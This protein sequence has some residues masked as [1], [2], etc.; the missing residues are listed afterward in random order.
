[1]LIIAGVILFYRIQFVLTYP[2]RT[3]N[4]VIVPLFK[5]KDQR[6][7]ELQYGFPADVF[8]RLFPACSIIAEVVYGYSTYE[9]ILNPDY[10]RSYTKNCRRAIRAVHGILSI[11]ELGYVKKSGQSTFAKRTPHKLSQAWERGLLGLYQVYVPVYQHDELK[12]GYPHHG[13]APGMM[14]ESRANKLRHKAR[15]CGATLAAW[16]PGDI[17]QYGCGFYT[18]VEEM[19]W[20][21]DHVSPSQYYL[22]PASDI[23]SISGKPCLF[24]FFFYPKIRRLHQC[25]YHTLQS[26]PNDL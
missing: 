6:W 12:H 19:Y 25:R 10:Y 26:S 21:D 1:M 8:G 2:Y 13:N 4:E 17:I 7:N 9:C 16:K 5:A 22:R 18:F 14:H 15:M 20:E 11:E 3:V 23:E 24:Q